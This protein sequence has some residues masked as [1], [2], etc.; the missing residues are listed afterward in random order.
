V[1]TS[2][3][4]PVLGSSTT[5]FLPNFT[6]FDHSLTVD[7]EGEESPYTASK[8]FLISV[9]LQPSRV[10]N[11]ITERYS[12]LSIPKKFARRVIETGI[13][14]ELTDLEQRGVIFYDKKMRTHLFSRVGVRFDLA[15]YVRPET[16]GPCIIKE[17]E[18]M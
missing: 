2:E 13:A 17:V 11:F 3:G 15:L 7:N 4:R 12:I 8:R 9:G 16:F 5:D 14:S 1:V 6:N 10:K 18:R